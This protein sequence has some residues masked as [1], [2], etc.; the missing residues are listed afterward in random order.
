[1]TKNHFNY[2]T[3]QIEELTI[4]VESAILTVSDTTWGAEDYDQTDGNW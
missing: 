2:V 4:V 1:M 3:P